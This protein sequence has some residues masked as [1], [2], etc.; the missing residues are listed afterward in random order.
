MVPGAPS[1]LLQLSQSPS[2]EIPC[3]QAPVMRRH[4]RYPYPQVLEPLSREQVPVALIEAQLPPAPESAPGSP[5]E[6]QVEPELQPLMAEEDTL[7]L[8]VSW[9]EDSFT[10]EVEE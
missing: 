1:P 2:Q 3:A 5:M 9:D 10:M 4:S 8:A 7:S 6:V